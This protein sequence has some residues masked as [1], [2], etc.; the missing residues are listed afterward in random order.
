[1]PLN[2]FHA[3][4]YRCYK[5]LVIYLV[6]VFVVFPG[7][8]Y[9]QNE[10]A[11]WSNPILINGSDFGHVFQAYFKTGNHNMLLALTSH[12]SRTQYGDSTILHYYNTMQFAY[13]IKLKA[14]KKEDNCYLLTYNATFLATAHI[15]VMKIVV[16]Q[17]TARIILPVGFNKQS[18]FLL[19]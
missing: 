18:Y 7:S 3:P 6:F 15:L 5:Q 13:P 4:L 10:H 9:S 8:V 14:H 17:D 1:M 11:N 16:E 12:E 2:P 19:R